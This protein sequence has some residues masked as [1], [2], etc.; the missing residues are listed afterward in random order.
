[1]SSS[2]HSFTVAL[3]LAAV[4]TLGSTTLAVAAADDQA[5]PPPPPHSDNVQAAAVDTATTAKVK[6][7]L[8]ADKRLA[9]SKISVATTDGVVTLTG[10]APS[11]TAA[12]AAEELADSVSGVKGVD[13]R[14]STSS[15]MESAAG[16]VSNATRSSERRASDDWITT[17]I[18]GQILADRSVER[19]SDINV[20]TT[21]G[22]VTL[23]GTAA[24]QTAFNHARDI[25]RSVK[26]VTSVDTADLRLASSR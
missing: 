11:V 16:K 23:S 22:A 14:I 1:M 24:S 25:A 12:S 4:V 17:K 7:R 5:Q 8:A 20:R 15:A 13:N 6:E 19:G 9:D 26:G 18:K 2:L 21:D 3:G 10:T